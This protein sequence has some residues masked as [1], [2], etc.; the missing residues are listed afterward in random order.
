M[1]IF[2]KLNHS[3][4]HFR[5]IDLTGCRLLTDAGVEM[6]AMMLF[7]MDEAIETVSLFIRWF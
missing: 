2:Q 7:E 5:H 4:F 6:L 1:V 3:R